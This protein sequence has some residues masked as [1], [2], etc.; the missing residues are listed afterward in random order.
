MWMTH[1]L[2]RRNTQMSPCDCQ[3]AYTSTATTKVVITLQ[4]GT[5]YSRP[6]ASG[7]ARY[8]HCENFYYPRPYI[9]PHLRL[10]TKTLDHNCYKSDPQAAAVQAK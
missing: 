10:K 1:S 8:I 6:K 9:P 5:Y 2:L 4:A 3:P 7:K